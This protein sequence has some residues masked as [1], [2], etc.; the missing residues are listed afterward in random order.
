MRLLL[1][2]LFSLVG[3]GYWYAGKRRNNT[4]LMVCGVVLGLFTY[5]VANP[6]WMIL[7][8][9]AACAFPFVFPEE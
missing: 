8:G 6:I 9:G 3:I 2:I 1:G 7:I 5:V 4:R